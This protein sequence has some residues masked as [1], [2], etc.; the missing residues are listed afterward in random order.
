MATDVAPEGM[1]VNG[2]ELAFGTI[3]CQPLQVLKSHYEV[4]AP[5]SHLKMPVLNNHTISTIRN[6]RMSPLNTLTNEYLFTRNIVLCYY[7]F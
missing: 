6:I 1:A 4:G 2:R 3:D 5:T 7:Y